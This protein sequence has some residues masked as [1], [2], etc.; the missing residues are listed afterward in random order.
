M[1]FRWDWTAERVV[2]RSF[3]SASR[4]SLV[5]GI[6]AAG[7]QRSGASFARDRQCQV[8]LRGIRLTAC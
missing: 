4:D 8:Y 6:M 2:S 1:S 5:G 3:S 7:G